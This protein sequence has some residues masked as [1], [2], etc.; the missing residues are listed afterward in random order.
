[1]RREQAGRDAKDQEAAT[2]TQII[3]DINQTTS[4]PP[5]SRMATNT[6]GYAPTR[7][8]TELQAEYML[9]AQTKAENE[10]VIQEIKKAA[11]EI[12]AE[13]ERLKKAVGKLQAQSEE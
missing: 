11:Q 12:Q 13:N 7:A 3:R 9:A 4:L 5:I 10:R 8:E 2:K 1:M 6:P